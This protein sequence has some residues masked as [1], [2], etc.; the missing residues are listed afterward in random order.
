MPAKPYYQWLEVPANASQQEIR[1]AY[2]KL[3][4][5][6]HPDKHKGHEQRFREIAE[7]YEILG[8]A[9][10]RSQFD[11][12]EVNF[13]VVFKSSAQVFRECFGDEEEEHPS[14]VV[15]VVSPQRIFNLPLFNHQSPIIDTRSAELFAKGR[16]MGSLNLPPGGNVI[17]FFEEFEAE[18]CPDDFSEI[19]LIGHSETDPH[20]LQV[21]NSL[22]QLIE[23]P[24]RDFSDDMS[25]ELK[26]FYDKLARSAKKEVLLVAGG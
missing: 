5:K 22:K 21:A 24:I 3:A 8:N 12:G 4:L 11:R 15:Q 13:D 7:A 17:S 10:K 16:I 25:I 19:V 9:E 6:Y 23:H 20:T 1:K 2:R 14:T 18:F 26:A